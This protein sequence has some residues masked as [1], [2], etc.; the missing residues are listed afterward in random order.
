MIVR[1]ED[2]PYDR[3]VSP[4]HYDFNGVQVIDITRHLSFTLGNVVKYVTRAGRK[5][6]ALTDLLKARKY[7]DWAIEDAEQN[8]GS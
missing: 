5:G 2:V 4:D 6:D 8:H 1:S 7:L 3:S